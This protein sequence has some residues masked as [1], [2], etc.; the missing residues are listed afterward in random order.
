MAIKDN[1]TF[2]SRDGANSCYAYSWAPEDGKIKA[3]FQIIHGM[4]EHMERYDAFATFLAD[5]GFLVVGEDH[6][7]HG[8]TISNDKD[9][10][11]MT[12]EHADIVLVRNAHRLKKITQE[13]NP[14]IPY[15][16]LGHSMGSF[17]MRKYLTMYGKGINGAIIMST[18][19]KP[20]IVTRTGIIFSSL[21][22]FA[23]SGYSTSKFL[24][25]CISGSNNK[26]IKNP[27]TDFDWLTSDKD[28]V[29]K[30]IEDPLCGYPFTVNA[31]KALFKLLNYVCK[32]R[33]LKTI[34][35]NLP[36]LVVCGD[37]DPVG[38][39]GKAP[40]RVFAQYQK[41]GIEDVTLKTY[42]NMRHEVL[43]ETDRAKVYEDILAWVEKHI[44]E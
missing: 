20:A 3:V 36:I 5:R 43:N 2:P 26:R 8:R 13:N 30:Y 37:A 21:K 32:T 27:S 10:S 31:Y 1:F 19:V 44:S 9:L 23:K 11:Y 41:L 24:E 15:F 33:N 28:I 16:I 17:I 38:N 4:Q 14:G 12:G 42:E 25:K 22:A 18:A 35:K 39:Y 29:N 34:P 40:R 7:G 6:I